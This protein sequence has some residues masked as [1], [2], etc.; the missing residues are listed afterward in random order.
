MVGV[1]PRQPVGCVQLPTWGSSFYSSFGG[2][3][4][5]SRT[6]L[7]QKGPKTPQLVFLFFVEM[8][9]EE[10]PDDR[11]STLVRNLSETA[12]D[13]SAEADERAFPDDK[14]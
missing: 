14:V 3:T 6:N 8:P 13:L 1:R 11:R 4:K 12:P 7:A 9:N 10:I 2:L 5:K